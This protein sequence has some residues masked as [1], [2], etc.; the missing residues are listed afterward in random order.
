MDGAGLYHGGNLNII[1]NEEDGESSRGRRGRNV[2]HRGQRGRGRPPRRGGTSS[3]TDTPNTTGRDPSQPRFQLAIYGD[4]ENDD[5]KNRDSEI[6]GA[7][8]NRGRERGSHTRGRRSA[9]KRHSSEQRSRSD[10]YQPWD[11]GSRPMDSDTQSTNPQ[12]TNRGK[13]GRGGRGR[14]SGTEVIQRATSVE[15]VSEK[16]RGGRT[17]IFGYRKLSELSASDKN[18]DVLLMELNTSRNGFRELLRDENLSSKSDWM[19]MILSILAQTFSSSQRQSVMELLTAITE[20]KFLQVNLTPYLNEILSGSVNLHDDTL[21]TLL[22]NVC[23]LVTEILKRTQMNISAV[24]LMITVLDAIVTDHR[25]HFNQ[26]LIKQIQEV[27]SMKEAIQEK[28]E[29]IKESRSR[30]T[31]VKEKYSGESQPPD[32]FRLLPILPAIKDLQFFERPFLRANKIDGGYDNLNH[33]LDVQ[34]RLLREDYVRPLREGIAD[35]RRQRAQGVLSKKIQDIRLYEKVQIIRP[36]CTHRGVLYMIQ[37]DVS[38]F[39]GVRWESSR[40]L[41]FGSLLCLS[42]DDF[43]TILFATVTNRDIKELSQGLVQVQFEQDMDIST[44]DYYIMA[45]TTA[46]F[47]AYRHVLEGLQETPDDMPLQRYIVECKTTQKPPKYLLNGIVTYDFS[48]LRKN[49]EVSHVPVINPLKWPSARQ[50][51]LDDSQYKALKMAVTKEFAIIQGPPGTGKTYVGWKIVHLLLHNKTQWSE[52]ETDPILVV[53]YTNHALDQ[54]LSEIADFTDK[55]IRIGGRCASD[56]LAPFM[57]KNYRRKAR[58]TK[59][60][61]KIVHER[62]SDCLKKMAVCRDKIETVSAKLHTARS[63]ILK[64]DALEK[65]MTLEQS[66]SLSSRFR[67]QSINKNDQILIWLELFTNAEPV[68]DRVFENCPPI[69]LQWKEE[70]LEGDKIDPMTESEAKKVGNPWMLTLHER[71]AL[72][73]FWLKTFRTNLSIE[74]TK[75]TNRYQKMFNP[76]WMVDEQ[77]LTQISERIANLDADLRRY[78]STLLREDRLLYILPKSL[79]TYVEEIIKKC[80]KR[81]QHI[82]AIDIWMCLEITKQNEALLSETIGQIYEDLVDVEEEAS[83][84]G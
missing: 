27:K 64:K 82:H 9:Q 36:M 41:L 56:K 38:K 5:V 58:E 18:P 2:H 79:S 6:A 49:N 78:R 3:R 73:K 22:E 40:R 63:G 20:E 26:E 53:C 60:V 21:C 39:K 32:D 80:P 62:K 67:D 24:T 23:I 14:G 47:E 31:A 55:I 72:Y 44:K 71:A 11:H 52:E 29:E 12:Y 19:V 37:F 8:Y 25:R 48:P 74:I 42:F 65:Y 17:R 83:G 61:S 15:N 30:T 84:R 69:F 76:Q 81:P 10:S 68:R 1:H 75:E 59:S 57:L 45:E 51:D 54:F 66:K 33:Y 46:Y 16:S 13:P 34:F 70:L 28:R 43:E 50:L 7:H 35:Y 4:D 77:I